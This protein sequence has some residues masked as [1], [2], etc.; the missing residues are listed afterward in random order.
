MFQIGVIPG[1]LQTPAYASALAGGGVRR[2]PSHTN[3]MLDAS[4]CWRSG[5]RRWCAPGPPTMLVVMDESCIRRPVVGAEVMDEQL[6]RLVE[7]AGLPNSMLQVAPYDIGERRSFNLSIN[8]LT[9]PDRS[10]IAYAESRAQ[11]HLDREATFVLS[12]LS[13]YRQLQ[14]ESLSQAESVAV[15]RQLRKG[16]S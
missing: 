11:G 13:A 9:L 7:F 6:Q 8:L 12:A 4:R 5:R 3:R 1:L 14:A 10:V 16:P 2:G 15:I